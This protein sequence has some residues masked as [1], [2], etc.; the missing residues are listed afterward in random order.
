M[1][2]YALD[3]A[4]LEHTAD[5]RAELDL[6]PLALLEANVGGLR[7]HRVELGEALSGHRRII[8]VAAPS[9]RLLDAKPVLEVDRHGGG[10][11]LAGRDGILRALAGHDEPSAGGAAPSFLRC[12]D[13]E[14]HTRCLHIDP[15]AP[16]RDAVEREEATVGMNRL[17]NGRNVAVWHHDAARRLDVRHANEPRLLGLDLGDNLLDWHWRVLRVGARLDGPRAHHDLLRGDVAHLKDV[18]PTV[19]EVPVPHH[20]ALLTRAE[21]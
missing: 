1:G 14:V 5:L 7:L 2:R 6:A 10:R 11:N 15:D 20:E 9:V 18:A 17:G 13:Q 4:A 21:R 8:H 16:R 3:A 12:A 19:A